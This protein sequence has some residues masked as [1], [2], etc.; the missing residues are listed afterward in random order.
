MRFVSQAHVAG[1]PIFERWSANGYTLHLM[2]CA[3]ARDRRFPSIRECIFQACGMNFLL[4]FI[5]NHFSI[6]LFKYL[7]NFTAGNIYMMMEEDDRTR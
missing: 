6:G 2:A 7:F 3:F 1:A 4:D 5:F